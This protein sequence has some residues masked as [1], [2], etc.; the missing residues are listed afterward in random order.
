M[1][2]SLCFLAGKGIPATHLTDEQTEAGAV[3]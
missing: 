2:E 3:R 1:P